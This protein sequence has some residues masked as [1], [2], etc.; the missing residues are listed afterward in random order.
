[1]AQAEPN[2][3]RAIGHRLDAEQW[4]QAAADIVADG[5]GLLVAGAWRALVRLIHR[6]PADVIEADP[7][8]CILLASCAWSTGDLIEVRQ[9]LRR[10]AALYRSREDVAGEGRVNLLL[11]LPLF[12][13]GD[14]SGAK[15]L[16]DWCEA[17]L[18]QTSPLRRLLPYHQLWHGVASGRFEHARDRF[19][20]V[21]DV[22]RSP[23]ADVLFDWMTLVGSGFRGHFLGLP[24]WSRFY[25]EFDELATSN[26]RLAHR[27][28]LLV[29]TLAQRA[30]GQLWRGEVQPAVVTAKQAQTE[31]DKAGGLRGARIDL[32][33][34]HGL[35]AA[36]LGQAADFEARM[37]ELLAEVSECRGYR[38]SWL[39]TF[40]LVKA[41][42]WWILGRREPMVEACMQAFHSDFSTALPFFEGALHLV[43]AYAAL[44][45]GDLAAA[46]SEVSAASA[47]RELPLPSVYGSVD[48]IR[49]YVHLL[50]GENDRAIEIFTT[51]LDQV[52]AE[53]S[54]GIL[55]VERKDVVQKLLNAVPVGHPA[56]A[57]AD[58]YKE[59]LVRAH[60][61]PAS[62]VHEPS[63]LSSLSRRELQVLDLIAAGASNKRIAN[64][65]FLSIHTVKRHVANIN[66]KLNSDSRGEAAA[67]YRRAKG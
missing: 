48:L 43:M 50:E 5:R 65:L 38:E 55:V 4:E 15:R 7:E 62:I 27:Q 41:R 19:E 51:L 32:L 46:R 12:A 45:R 25:R 63:G 56:R 26:L 53:Q 13:L 40:L 28:P 35:L 23:D 60:L 36:I 64:E 57:L 66:A 10:A 22:A 18:P 58:R 9:Q 6:V 34:L 44:E 2:P 14:T 39:P 67:M 17:E 33:Q 16:L 20:S 1:A 37:R 42:G 30:W 21:L 54:L 49:A 29:A 31:N 61:P 3:I 24:G 11:V 52:A 59:M 8:L 47:V